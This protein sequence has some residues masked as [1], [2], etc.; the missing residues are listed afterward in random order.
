M[1]E[2][3]Q[4]FLTEDESATRQVGQ[5]LAGELG[6][7][8][9]VGLI[10]PLGAGK[11]VLVRGICEALGVPA[12]EVFSPSFAIVNTYSGREQVFHVDL[13]RVESQEEVESTGLF[14]LTGTGV[15]LIEWIDRV[16]EMIEPGT[17]LVRIEDLGGQ[18]RRLTFERVGIS[19]G[20]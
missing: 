5:R 8:D 14:D 7:G 18:R 16:D 20:T 12:E 3:F 2:V 6:E 15:M 17:I 4:E 9:R 19:R 1:R 10:G 11:T 13:Y